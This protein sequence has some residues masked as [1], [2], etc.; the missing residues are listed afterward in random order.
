MALGKLD[1][2]CALWRVELGNFCYKNCIRTWA[3]TT[4]VLVDGVGNKIYLAT[5]ATSLHS[6][7]RTRVPVFALLFIAWGTRVRQERAWSPQ[8]Q[9]QS[10]SCP[11]LILHSCSENK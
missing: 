1:L 8:S 3:V 4:C 6:V 2:F 5:L 9:R 11:I 10:Q 7:L